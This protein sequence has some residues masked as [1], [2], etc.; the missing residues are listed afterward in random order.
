MNCEL[1]QAEKLSKLLQLRRKSE[2]ES[3]A[4]EEAEALR[5]EL[6][7]VQ[8]YFESLDIA[9]QQEISDLANQVAFSFLILRPCSWRIVT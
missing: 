8:H 9:S 6:S 4:K 1:I 5:S 7:E 3:P 2:D